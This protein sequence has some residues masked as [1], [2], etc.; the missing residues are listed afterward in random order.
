MAYLVDPNAAFKGDQGASQVIGDLHRAQFADWKA[1]FAP[2]IDK[3]AAM[4]TD[5]SLPER[6][7]QQASDAVGRSYQGARTALQLQQQ[8]LGLQ[9]DPT[10]QQAQTRKFALSEA[11]AKVNAGNKARTSAQDLQQSILAGNMAMPK[12]ALQMQ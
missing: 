10:E 11:A 6:S 2:Q 7:A 8:G 1:R 3:L 4:A 9:L 5:E 12:T